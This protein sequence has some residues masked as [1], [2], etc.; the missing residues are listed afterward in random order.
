MAM[1]VTKLDYC[2]F[3]WNNVSDTRYN[4]LERLQT[5]AARIILKEWN[6]SHDESLKHLGWKSLRLRITMLRNIFVFRCSN[7][8]FS[9]L[10]NKYFIKTCHMHFTRGNDV[11]QNFHRSRQKKFVLS[12]CC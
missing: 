6:I 5:R 7:C 12:G 4:H 8:N 10:F 9:D 2:D 1:I 3:I 11:A